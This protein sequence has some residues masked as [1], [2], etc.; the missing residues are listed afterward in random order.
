MGA[1]QNNAVL[2]VEFLEDH[3]YELE[4][5]LGEDETEA[6]LREL[7]KLAGMEEIQ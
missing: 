7:R 3:I 2:L 1:L 5:L 4:Q 6:V